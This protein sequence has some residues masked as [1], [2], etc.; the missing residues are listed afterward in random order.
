MTAASNC[1]A[2]RP[3]FQNAIV[4]IADYSR[5]RVAQRGG[6]AAC[7]SST[8][9]RCRLRPAQPFRAW[10]GR[11]IW[12]S[13]Y[14]MS[15]CRRCRG[16]DRDGMGGAASH[17]NGDG[18]LHPAALWRPAV[19]IESTAADLLRGR[20]VSARRSHHPTGEKLYARRPAASPDGAR[21]LA[22]CDAPG[23]RLR[24]TAGTPC[25]V[26]HRAQMCRRDVLSTSRVD[27]AV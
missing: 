18:S 20:Q 25:A 10:M 2:V 7:R 19:P 14:R 4:L 6:M 26:R 22:L 12:R 27:R 13:W 9:G 8:S 11:V 15:A 17:G 5:L 21:R 1:Y 24:P 23:A 3:I 16:A